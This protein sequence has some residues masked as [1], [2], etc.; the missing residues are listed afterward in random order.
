MSYSDEAQAVAAA[1]MKALE[2]ATMRSRADLGETLAATLSLIVRAMIKEGATPAQVGGAVHT[3]T[4]WAV[5]P[6]EKVR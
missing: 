5:E 4:E 2:A 1:A 6:P 3:G